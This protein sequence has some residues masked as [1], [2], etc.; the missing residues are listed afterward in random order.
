MVDAVTCEGKRKLTGYNSPA[1][2]SSS[3]FIF[4][5]FASAKKKRQSIES[6]ML[7]CLICY[8]RFYGGWRKNVV[9]TVSVLFQPPLFW[10][11]EGLA[12]TIQFRLFSFIAREVSGQV[13]FFC[14][15]QT[16]SCRAA[17]CAR[18][19]WAQEEEKSWKLPAFCP[20]RFF[21]SFSAKVRRPMWV[22]K[23]FL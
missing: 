18:R 11:V 2:C 14:T 20:S 12:V 17:I 7:R 15:G 21:L 1:K 16:K 22:G 6:C 9:H 4:F 3:F 19:H 10:L 13:V 23:G 5:C 8:V